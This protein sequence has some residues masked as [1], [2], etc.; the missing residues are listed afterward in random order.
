MLPVYKKSLAP[1]PL[2]AGRLWWLSAIG[3]TQYL[4]AARPF[5]TK[6]PTPTRSANVKI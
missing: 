5:S 6:F 2:Q 4:A 3:N 1:E